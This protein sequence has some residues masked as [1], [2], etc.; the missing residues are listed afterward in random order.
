MPSVWDTLGIAETDDVGTVRSAY[1]RALKQIDMDADPRAYIALREARDHALQI[2]RYAAAEAAE[3][4]MLGVAAPPPPAPAA[5][6]VGFPEDTFEQHFSALTRL[7]AS[8]D[9]SRSPGDEALIRARFEALVG[10]LM[11]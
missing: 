4:E 3:D 1:A 5:M 2:I 11:T 7:L 10:E 9:A 8:D 6:V